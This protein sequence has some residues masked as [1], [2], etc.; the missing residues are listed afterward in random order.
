[1]RVSWKNGIDEEIRLF[2]KAYY[3]S[4]LQLTRLTWL[5]WLTAAFPEFIYFIGECRW[6][7]VV[8]TSFPS[9]ELVQFAL[10]FV[11]DGESPFL[12]ISDLFNYAALIGGSWA[13]VR[14]ISAPRP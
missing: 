7:S 6:M 3:K 14:D 8:E 4:C 10:D 11:L 13:A 12:E 9:R 1:M 2:S 5:E